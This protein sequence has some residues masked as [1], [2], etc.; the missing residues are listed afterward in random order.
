MVCQLCWRTSDGTPVYAEPFESG[1]CTVILQG[2]QPANGVVFAVVC[3][4]TYKYTSALLKKHFSYR[5]ALGEGTDGTAPVTTKW[6][7]YDQKVN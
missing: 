5:I 1:S 7:N 4:R 2:K 6:F 3:N